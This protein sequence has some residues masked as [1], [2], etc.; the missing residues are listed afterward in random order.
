MVIA[1]I[2]KQ[3]IIGPI[4]VFSALTLITDLHFSKP[5]TLHL[6]IRLRFRRAKFIGHGLQYAVVVSNI[7]RK[8]ITF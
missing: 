5:V 8:Y 1:S 2:D 3:M 7:Q 4:L 6:R